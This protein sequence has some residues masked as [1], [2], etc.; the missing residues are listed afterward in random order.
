MKKTASL[1]LVGALLITVLPFTLVTSA[2]E[3]VSTPQAQQTLTNKDVTELLKSGLSAEIIIAKIKSSP[4]KFD[5]STAALLEL[6]AADMPESVV[7]AMI[8]ANSPATPT[9]SGPLTKEVA[10]DDG[11]SVEIE[12]LTVASSEV[13]KVGDVVDFKVVQSVEFKGVT[14]IEKGSVA[15]GHIT[16]ARKAGF[17][18]RAGKLEWVMQYAVGID[19]SRIPLRFTQRTVGD[20]KGATVAIAAVATTFLLGPVSLLWGLKRGKPVIIPSGNRYYVFVQGT[21][22]VKGHIVAAK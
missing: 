13:M 9:V 18:G 7:L 17:W 2:Q 4:S 20:S 14:I 19:N 12:L 8:Q 16:E 6:K 21:P 10:V 11:T 1:V 22:N 3:V 5:T 15:K